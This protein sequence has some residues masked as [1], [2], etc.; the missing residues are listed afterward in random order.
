M[1]RPRIDV[2][3]VIAVAWIVFAVVLTVVLGPRLGMRGL[4]WLGLHHL[5]C[6][7]GAG[8]ELWRARGR[9]LARHAPEGRP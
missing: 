4:L 9:R 3:F 2:G 7:A 1:A 5:L 6:A 8:H